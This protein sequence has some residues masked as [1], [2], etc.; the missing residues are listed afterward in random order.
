M[1]YSV[2]S[3]PNSMTIE[4]YQ[5]Q[6]RQVKKDYEKACK[7]YKKS[8]SIFLRED[9]EDLRQDMIELQVLINEMKQGKPLH[10]CDS[11]QFVY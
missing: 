8:K 1:M 3:T 2:Q 4:E 5:Q 7:Q 11:S 9:I 6:L 10:Q